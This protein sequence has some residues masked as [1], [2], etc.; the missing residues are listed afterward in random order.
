MRLELAKQFG[1]DVTINSQRE[2]PA[3]LVR[4][5]SGGL[6]ADVAIEAVGVPATFELC[7]QL[8][9]PTGRVANIGVHGHPVTLALDELWRRPTTCF[10]GPPTRAP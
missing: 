5:L 4:E 1:A 9:R 2:D 8:V 3:A 10:R 6:G 7:T